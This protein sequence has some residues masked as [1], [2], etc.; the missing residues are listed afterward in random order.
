[1]DKKIILYS[2]VMILSVFISS[3]SQI[4]LKKS[5]LENHDNIVEEYINYR[6]VIAY[7]MFFS[8]TFITIYALK[9]VPL[10]MAPLLDSFGYIFISVLSYYFLNEKVSRNQSYGI[11]LI[12]IGNIIFS[13]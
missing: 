3:I 8:C 12:I 7:I 10:S 5:A 1:M 4:I 2:M 9:V 6:V 13:I 11:L